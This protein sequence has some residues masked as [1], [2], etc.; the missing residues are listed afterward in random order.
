MK[1]QINDKEYTIK[2]TKH[3][4]MINEDKSGYIIKKRNSFHTFFLKNVDIV[5]LNKHNKVLLKYL[6]M[7]YFKTIKVENKKEKTNIL[8]LPS[9]ASYGIKIGDILTFKD[10][11]I[12]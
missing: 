8:I 1:I 4:K 9:N 6:N 7:P 3:I 10:E 11:H 5:F 2:N 12:V